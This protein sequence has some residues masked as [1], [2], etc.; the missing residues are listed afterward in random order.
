MSA[1]R[2]VCAQPWAEEIEQGLKGIKMALK[3]LR[4]Y[5]A[6]GDKA[7]DADEGAGSGIIGLLEVVESDFTKGLSE[8]T[9]D[10]DLRASV[11]S[12]RSA[13][14]PMSSPMSWCE[15][16]SAMALGWVGGGVA[17]CLG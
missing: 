3:V 9:S 16:S 15:M 2:R 12:M 4:E 13:E 1:A 14:A 5:Y 6:K 8:M 11:C 17:A 7:H 10:E